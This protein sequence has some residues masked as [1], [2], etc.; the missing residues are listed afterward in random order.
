MAWRFLDWKFLDWKFLVTFSVSI[1]GVVVPVVWQ[2]DPSSKGM[3]LRLNSITSLEPASQIHDLQLMLDGKKLES[4]FSS[5][6]ELINTGSKAVLSKDFDKPIEINLENG[7]K[8]ITARITGTAPSDIPVE[9][10]T[11]DNTVRIAPHLSNSGDSVSLNIITS[12]KKPV[13]SVRARIAGIPHVTYTDLTLPK[14]P[15]IRYLKPALQGLC[16][17]ALFCLNI[18]FLVAW[19]SPR[20]FGIPRAISSFVVATSYISGAQMAVLMVEGLELQNRWGILATILVIAVLL[21]IA[22]AAH[23]ALRWDRMASKLNTAP[24]SFGSFKWP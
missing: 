18:M 15:Y 3:E 6:V 9:V 11:T 19:L 4:P 23:L 5:T 14:S 21:G 12:G 1:L 16:A 20:D 8:V 24:S 17:W 2:S 22:V 7:A 10:S 13:Y